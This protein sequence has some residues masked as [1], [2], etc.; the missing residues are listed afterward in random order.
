MQLL[1][2]I[3]FALHFIRGVSATAYWLDLYNTFINVAGSYVGGAYNETIA[4][5]LM[6]FAG[7][8][9]WEGFNPANCLPGFSVIANLSTTVQDDTLHGFVGYIKDFIV[10]SVEGSHTWMELFHEGE[11]WMS[12]PQPVADDLPELKVEWYWKKV[13]EGM[14]TQ[15]TEALT[16][17]SKLCPDCRNVY[18][19]GHSLGAAVITIDLA[20]MKYDEWFTSVG[21]THPIYFYS[22]GSPRPGNKKFAKYAQD[23][24][25]L[26]IYRVVH[27][28]DPAVHIP[29]CETTK[30]HYCTAKND[31]YNPWHVA[32]EI[33]YDQGFA[34]HKYCDGSGEDPSCSDSIDLNLLDVNEHL[35]YFGA[36]VSAICPL[37]QTVVK[38]IPRKP[39]LL[40]CS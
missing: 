5:G 8:S 33:F 13:A 21:W 27:H 31:S 23:L 6:I 37:N 11:A 20:L 14:K 4:K 2:Y 38:D 1:G 35:Y 7:T 39:A 10:I 19:T 26:E 17:A 40:S 9:Y 24:P 29:C 15:M 25:G 30:D 34:S 18:F 22:F 32:G 28:A 12:D 16:Q 3:L 36:R